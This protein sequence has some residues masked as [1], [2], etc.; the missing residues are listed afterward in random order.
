MGESRNTEVCALEVDAPEVIQDGRGLA[1]E[2]EVAGA[3]GSSVYT[4]DRACG[5]RLRVGEQ[6]QWDEDRGRPEVMETGVPEVMETGVPEDV[7]TRV[8]AEKPEVVQGSRDR[9][10]EE[11]APEAVRGGR[12]RAR[13]A[14]FGAPK[15]VPGGHDLAIAVGVGVPESVVGLELR[16]RVGGAIGYWV[17]KSGDTEVGVLEVDT[18][19]VVRG[20]CGPAGGVEV[21][22]PGSVEGLGRRCRVGG[23]IG[24]GVV[25]SGSPEN[26]EKSGTRNK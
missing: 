4:D 20:G 18:P 3:G 13:E 25:Y 12:N 17:R 11:E 9:V 19:A 26:S 15:V 23:A 24:Y 14:I 7:E 10:V 21:G 2:A 5:D 8:K 22:V 1:V 6:T 16:G